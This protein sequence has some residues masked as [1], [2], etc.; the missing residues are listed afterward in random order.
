MDYHK[1]Y[2]KNDDFDRAYPQPRDVEFAEPNF[3]KVLRLPV[4]V[5]LSPS[6]IQ[7]VGQNSTKTARTEAK[8]VLARANEIFQHPSMR[9]TQINLVYQ[10]ATFFVAAEELHPIREDLQRL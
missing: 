7:N 8:K 2:L 5:Y 1:D 3:P 4:H 9:P 6:W 10:D